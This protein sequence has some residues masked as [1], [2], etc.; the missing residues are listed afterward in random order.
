MEEPRTTMETTHFS[1]VIN[2]TTET[3]RTAIWKGNFF[4]HPGT[5]LIFG[6]EDND[7]TKSPLDCMS[8][9]KAVVQ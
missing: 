3:E 8:S 2:G 1:P 4:I 7:P 5:S 6:P 9:V